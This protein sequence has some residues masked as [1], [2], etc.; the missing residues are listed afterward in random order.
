MSKDDNSKVISENPD[1][2]EFKSAFLE[3]SEN[4]EKLKVK[5]ANLKNKALSLIITVEELEGEKEEFQ[6]KIE[7][8][9]SENTSLE[10]NLNASKKE[11]SLVSSEIQFLRGVKVPV[12]NEFLKSQLED[13]SIQKINLE[14]EIE[15][16]NFTLSKFTKGRENLDILLGRQRWLV[17]F[18]DNS[19]GKIIGE[20]KLGTGSI[21]IDNVSLVDGLKFNLIS[22]S[23]L[24][25]SGHKVM[26]EG[27]R[28]LISHASDGGTLVGKRDDNIYTLSFDASD[29]SREVCLSVEHND[30]WLWHRR[31]G[32]V[33]MDLIKKLLS[34][35]LVKGLPKLREFEMS[36]MGELTFF[37]GLQ[38]KQ[39]KEGIFISQSKY[40]RELLK[41][42]GL[43][44]AKPR[45]FSDSDYAGCLVDRKST[46]GT[47]QFLSD[48]LVSWHSKKQT[49]VALSTAEAEY[50][51]AGSCCAQVLWMRQ[52][53]RDF[54]VS[55]DHIPI[56]CDSSS[57][58]DISKNPVQHS[59][60]K[61]IDIRHHFLRDNVQKGLIELKK[62]GSEDQLADFFTKP[63]AES[64]FCS[65]RR[66]LGMCDLS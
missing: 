19:N 4:Y 56:M 17:T 47:C 66:R 33:H 32:H 18:G 63:L 57:A 62:V 21:S 61:H 49:S 55:M 53:L 20:G 38:I 30:I 45:G 40:T 8:Y 65:L 29:S 10:N 16:L 28:C 25:D 11:N 54:G 26:F 13:I 12:D 23:Q 50:V 42:F 6:E 27:D 59:R 37:L 34:K 7:L 1:Y 31:L 43:D 48:A 58:I 39:S 51:A 36:M 35:D 14:K 64:S 22:I 2:N 9:I 3:L 46:S 15:D 41:R 52:T 60:T 5:N 44:N 24:I